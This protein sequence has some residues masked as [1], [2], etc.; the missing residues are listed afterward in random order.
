MQEEKKNIIL[1]LTFEFSLLAIDF[2]TELENQKKFV[3]ANQLLRSATSIGANANEAQLAESK[4]DFIHKLKIAE[5]EANETEYWLKLCMFS[6]KL[7]NCQ[8]LLDKLVSIRKVLSKIIT[9][10]K[11]SQST[12]S[13]Q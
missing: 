1:E 11:S 6:E 7:P 2:C 9:S 10:A 13:N 5:K 8:E 3:I 12:I 4:A